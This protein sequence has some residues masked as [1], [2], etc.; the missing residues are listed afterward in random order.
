M[1]PN[2]KYGVLALS[3]LAALMATQFA[4]PTGNAQ[5][6]PAP[7]PADKITPLPPRHHYLNSSPVLNQKHADSAD[8][9][10]TTRRVRGYRMSYG[11]RPYY[12]YYYIPNTNPGMTTGANMYFP[13][14]GSYAYGFTAD[15][16]GYG[17]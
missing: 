14:P 6:S 7:V 1:F 12:Y 16:Y 4:S 17:F 2:L 5:D 13:D 15:G 11:Y 3:T 8:I 9:E 10:A